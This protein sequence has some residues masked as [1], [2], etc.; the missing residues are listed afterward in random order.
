MQKH[1]A[2]IYFSQLKGR[3]IC[4]S[5]GHTV[6]KVKDIVTLWSGGLPIITGILYSEEPDKLIPASIVQNWDGKQILLAEP[7]E[8]IKTIQISHQELFVGKWLLDNQVIDLKGYKIVRVN[9]ILLSCDEQD[10]TQHLSI[11]AADIG[12]RGLLRRIGLEFLGSSLEK[13]YIS[14]QNIT[15][16]EKRTGSLKLKLDKDHFKKLHPV[17]IA[18]LLEDM[19]YESRS[20]FF[21]A[22]GAEQAAEA[23]GK[24]KE[25]TQVEIVTRMDKEQAAQL[26][27]DLHADEAAS[28][29]REMPKEKAAE[30]LQL[31]NKDKAKE[32]KW[33]LHYKNDTAGSLMTTEFIR[34]PIT[35]TAGQ[36]VEHLRRFAQ[37]AE[38]INYLYVTDVDE[39]LLGVFSLRELILAE[40][41][42]TLGSLMH[43][44]VIAVQVH[45]SS[46]KV[47]DIVH[48]YGLLAVPV[49]DGEGFL[50]GI[51]TVDDVLDLFMVDRTLKAAMSRYLNKRGLRRK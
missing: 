47:A 16:L 39:K 28:I 6:G 31:L 10:G 37:D 32:L 36:A 13:K 29:L 38:M 11:I 42:I 44:K 17:D 9:D 41:E 2:E 34:L 5:K 51:V 26:L 4:D 49:L 18:D 24:L 30:L 35:F 12:I 23:I 46:K 43:S 50:H 7:S 15:P 3:G 27:E 19:D 8:K 45:D 14:W 25:N 40:P 1:I 20:A 21:K 48:K 33:L 22:L